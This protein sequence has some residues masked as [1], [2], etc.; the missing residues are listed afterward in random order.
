MAYQHIL[1]MNIYQSLRSF[2][3][4]RIRFDHLYAGFRLRLD[5]ISVKNTPILQPI[6]L[7]DAIYSMAYRHKYYKYI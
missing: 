4:Y 6:G 2:K 3:A 5:N 1:V 7:H